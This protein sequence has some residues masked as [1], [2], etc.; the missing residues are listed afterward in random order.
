V[1]ALL[2]GLLLLLAAAACSP[3]TGGAPLTY[4]PGTPRPAE[5]DTPAID[6]TV[7]DLTQ[8][9][10]DQ[11]LTLA[12]A[13]KPFRPAEGPALAAAPRAVYQVVLPE[14]PDQGYVVIYDLP[15]STTATTAGTDQATYLGTGPGRV[16]MPIGTRHVLRQ[17][18][19]TILLYSWIPDGATDERAPRIEDALDAVGTGIPIPS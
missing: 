4:P 10:G 17:L 12:P 2:G 16:Q 15:D 7:A 19:S 1:R 9:L 6:V 11:G 5:A 3:A 13:Q 18:G 8:A 14:A